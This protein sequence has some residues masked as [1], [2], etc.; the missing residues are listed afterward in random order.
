M[1]ATQ[2]AQHNQAMVDGLG[3]GLGLFIELIANI[4]EQRRFLDVERVGYGM[5]Y[6]PACEMQQIIGIGAQGTERELAQ[7][8][9]I[10][11]GI[12]P[13]DFL[14]LVRGQTVRREAGRRGRGMEERDSHND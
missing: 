11:K 1:K 13:S 9:G 2:T 4:S 5:G 8:L 3:S 14:P 7:A 6:A 12:G 10:E